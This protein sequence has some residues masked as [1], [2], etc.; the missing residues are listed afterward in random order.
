M[1]P[2]GT[3]GTTGTYSV[4]PGAGT[5]RRQLAPAGTAGDRWHHAEPPVPTAPFGNRLVL[6]PC[7]ADWYLWRTTVV[8]DYQC[9]LAV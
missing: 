5:A 3:G 8:L 4:P 2:V 7:G 6:A 9:L 1:V